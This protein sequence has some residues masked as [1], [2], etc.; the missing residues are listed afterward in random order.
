[1][2]ARVY[3]GETVIAKLGPIERANI[4]QRAIA[5][6][7][8]VA[9]RHG[10]HVQEPAVLA[11]RYA[12]RVHLRPA[13][14][15][16]RVSTFTATLRAP[17]AA[18]LEREVAVT[19]Y[20]H[21]RGAPVVPP[22]A[23]LP[24]GPHEEDG[25]SLSFWEHVA[26][27]TEEPPSPEVAGRMLA[28]LHRVLRDYPGE[29][30]V[31]APPLNDIPRGLERIERIGD[32]LAP[33]ELDMLRKV[34]DRLLPLVTAPAELMQPLHGDAHGYN[35]ISTARGLFW[36]DFEDT[37]KGPIGWDLSTLMDA[38]GKMLEGYP[39]APAPA[40]L[41]PYRHM[42]LLQAAVWVFALAPEVD[43]WVVQARGMLDALRA[44]A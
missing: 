28:E 39:G 11:D 15:V 16:A 8:R 40:E 4:R 19:A 30:P 9:A 37:C 14:I 13:P 22:S 10:V 31:L 23:L 7:A 26:P 42:R 41:E 25:F 24:P 44:L 1:M 29:L 27:N 6:A 33:S 5:A 35:L 36:N 17:I 20:L 2:S 34:A 18:W 21:A 43:E 3:D 12:V 32:V 38:E